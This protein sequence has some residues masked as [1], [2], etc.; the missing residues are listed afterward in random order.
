[1]RVEPLSAATQR[2]VLEYLDRAPYDNVFISHIL[3]HDASYAS[4]HVNVIFDEHGVA[5]VVYHGRHIVIA[6]DLPAIPAL[7]AS[8][9][10]HVNARMIIGPRDAVV[11]L[12]KLLGE[13]Y[14]RPRLVR[15]RQ[16]VMMVD[17]RQL[18]PGSRT[19]TVRHA[20]LDEWR[21]V[22]DGSA[23][24]IQQELEYD[25]RRGMPN[26]DVGVRQ[27]IERRLWWVGL[28]EGTLCFFCHIGPW[29][30]RTLQLQGIWTPRPLRVRGL[31]TASLSAICDRLL[32]ASPTLSLYVNDFNDAAI[33]LYRR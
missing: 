32:E 8:L 26:F 21:T 27:M 4:K 33:A 25:P 9:P 15:D 12:W 23:E 1:M 17:R 3:L 22:A 14:G 2:A 29:S 31:A 19:V 28:S 13:R 6:A 11:E 10:R 30:S 5:G 20:R 16:L 7:A 18:R 24:M